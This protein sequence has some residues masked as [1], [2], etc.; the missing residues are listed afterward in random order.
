[1]IIERTVSVIF[2]KEKGICRR[3]SVSKNITYAYFIYMCQFVSAKNKMFLQ[4]RYKLFPI[5]A[6][7]KIMIMRMNIKLSNRAIVYFSRMHFP[8]LW[9]K[10][11]ACRRY[12]K[13][14]G[15]FRA[16]LAFLAVWHRRAWNI[17]CSR[18]LQ[19]RVRRK[20]RLTQST[21]LL[22]LSLSHLF[23]HILCFLRFLIIPGQVPREFNDGSS[24]QRS[25]SSPFYFLLE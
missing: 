8:S 1:M 25:S 4:S 7:F 11:S 20:M 24:F 5:K 2:M 17:S 22:F 18:I 14:K 3:E 13:E 10:H 21:C 6:R 19:I 9:I 15:Q 23:R 12:F 16:F